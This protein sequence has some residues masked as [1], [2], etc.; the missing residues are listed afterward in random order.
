[1]IATSCQ[2]RGTCGMISKSFMEEYKKIIEGELALGP[3]IS[4][5]NLID[6]LIKHA[7][8]VGA[9]DIHIDPSDKAIRVRF[10]V[11]GVL[12]NFYSLP[13]SI[14]P[15]IISRIKVLASLR[16]DEHNSAQDGRFRSIISSQENMPGSV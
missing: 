12:E 3:E 11:D 2:D 4:I 15:E 7:S 16:S 10:R 13:K 9:S 14:H 1:M 8:A 5:I 6:Q